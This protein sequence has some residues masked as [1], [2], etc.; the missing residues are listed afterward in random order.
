M[1]PQEWL[2]KWMEL[3]SDFADYPQY[4]AEEDRKFLLEL[5]D[6]NASRIL[7]GI[8]SQDKPEQKRDYIWCSTCPFCYLSNNFRNFILL[9]Y[10]ECKAC[11]YGVRHSQCDIDDS[12]YRRFRERFQASGLPLG[13][14]DTHLDRIPEVLD[15]FI[16]GFANSRLTPSPLKE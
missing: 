3:K 15:E 16:A 5:S 8:N 1:T 4:F 14:L 11:T 6:D 13:P 10:D 2:V 9:Y 12:D 7:V